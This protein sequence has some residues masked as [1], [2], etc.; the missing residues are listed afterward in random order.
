MA[1]A[2]QLGRVTI[3]DPSLNAV[4]RLIRREYC[5]QHPGAEPVPTTSGNVNVME[6]STTPGVLAPIADELN[7]LGYGPT[8]V[9][10]GYTQY[11]PQ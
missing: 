4:Q 2:N 6:W 8:L 5:R 10:L 9:T 1:K 7:Q 11:K 3:Q